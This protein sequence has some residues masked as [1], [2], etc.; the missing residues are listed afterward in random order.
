MTGQGDQK[1]M[2]VPRRMEASRQHAGAGQTAI[3]TAHPLPAA[4]LRSW[5]RCGDLGLDREARKPLADPLPGHELRQLVQ[6]HELLRRRCRPELEALFASTRDRETIAVLTSPE[7]I[8][9]DVTGNP[10]FAGKAAQ[11][12]LRPG[13]CWAEDMTGTNAIGAALVERRGVEVRGSQHFFTRNQILTC[14]AVPVHSPTGELLGVLDLSGNVEADHGFALGLVQLA[15]DGLEHREFDHGFPGCELVRLHKDPALVGT[16]R[17]GVLVFRDHILIAANRHGLGLL[18]LDWAALGRRTFRNLFPW[19]E[20]AGGGTIKFRD[21]TGRVIHARQT[22]PERVHPARVPSAEPPLPQAAPPARFLDSAGQARLHRAARLLDASVPVLVQGETGTGKEVFARA[23]HAASLR[24]DKPFV[25]INCTALPESLIESELFGYEPGAF[26][27]ARRGGAKGLLREADGGLL[28]LDEIGDMPL[29]LQP[30]LLRALQEREVLPVGGVKAVPIDVTVICATHRDLA[31]LVSDGSFR[32][33]LY[34]RI[35]S[36][37]IE[38]P[39]I[40]SLPDPIGLIQNLWDSLNPK[41]RG[42]SLAA[43]CEAALAAYHWPG[44]FRQLVGSLK[45]MLALAE[46]GECLGIDAL[47]ANL[48]DARA[49]HSATQPAP[50]GAR[51]TPKPDIITSPARQLNT[52]ERDAMREAL[53]TSGGNVAQAARELGISRS[54]L[55]RRYLSGGKN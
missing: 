31:Q 44:N 20:S 14:A 38:L 51:A 50:R 21:S 40:R 18:D 25:A 12:A 47:P 17:E 42:V 26:T 4:I 27:G 23:A 52:I 5:K 43:D 11:V 33:D 24:R 9:L 54:K 37:T 3:E 29:G 45:A 36:Y 7:G 1:G 2:D 35:A 30:R 16:S 10:A 48:R 53:H 6:R 41:L 15:V 32:G 39:A 22:L 49:G 13:A 46:D 28:F 55:Y 34:Y 8:I 19:Q